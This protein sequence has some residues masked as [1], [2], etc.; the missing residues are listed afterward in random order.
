MS[1]QKRPEIFSGIFLALQCCFLSVGVV[2]KRMN[3]DVLNGK[4]DRQPKLSS[5]AVSRAGDCSAHATPLKDRWLEGDFRFFDKTSPAT[6]ADAFFERFADYFE[7]G[8]DGTVGIMLNV[9]WFADT[10][11]AY[12]GELDAQIPLAVFKPLIIEGE[13]SDETLGSDPWTYLQIRDLVSA[14]RESATRHVGRSDFRIGLLLLGWSSIYYGVSPVWFDAHPESFRWTR[15]SLVESPMLFLDYASRLRPDTRCYA[16]FP[17]GIPQALPLWKFFAA[18]WAHLSS[19]TGFD[20]IL[21]RDGMLGLTNYRHASPAWDEACFQGLRD[22]LREIKCLS[23]QTMTI[24]YSTAGS[25]IAELRCMSFDLRTLA[26]D[27]HLDAWITQSWGCNWIET[28]RLELT[29]AMQVATICVHRALLEGTGVKHYPTINLLDAFEF[30]TVRSFSGRWQALR[31]EIW[32]YTHAALIRYWDATGTWGMH[33]GAPL[34]LASGL[35]GAMFHVGKDML[36]AENVGTLTNELNLA[37]GDARDMADIGGVNIVVHDEYARSLNHSPDPH[38]YHGEHIDETAGLLIRAGIPILSSSRITERNYAKN[39]LPL[40]LHNPVALPLDCLAAL[41]KTPL[42]L[43]V[44]P[45]EFT[46]NFDSPSWN[47]AETVDPLGDGRYLK[48][49]L[50]LPEISRLATEV[51]RRLTG[52]HII[53]P[54]EACI[55]FHYW[56]GSDGA[57]QMLFGNI[58]ADARDAHFELV[59]GRQWLEE[60][61]IPAEAKL[62]QFD[63]ETFWEP[64]PNREG[65]VFS[66]SLGADLSLRC[67]MRAQ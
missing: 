20:T 3:H 61:G 30:K 25:A 60:H 22:F 26:K 7:S 51:S 42:A 17:N 53:A 56:H 6:S 15:P 34:S 45:S 58:E 35:Y 5:S 50:M 21:L 65:L 48:D 2:K 13:M 32:A 14:L 59:I 46:V 54:P 38:A 39:T 4:L 67:F 37:V 29:P 33:E 8:Q 9:G 63:G 24:G 1:R 12:P 64:T 62:E 66:F 47:P 31:W 55:H 27:G 11:L 57:L 18:Q 28:K 36:S 19:D 44:G 16:S 52:P 40:L 49:H 23:P 10:V 43:V 41:K